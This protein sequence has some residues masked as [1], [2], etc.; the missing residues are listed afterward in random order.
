MLDAKVRSRFEAEYRT[1]FES[2]GYGTTVYSPLCFGFLTGKYNEGT[3]PKDS[4]GATWVAEKKWECEENVEQF[5]GPEVVEKT[6]STLQGL[7]KIAADFG[8]TQAQ[9]AL[10]WVL[11][12]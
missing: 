3:L 4:R 9:F 8:C 7:A 1:L 11:V 6:K 12:H 10:A 5:F 2:R